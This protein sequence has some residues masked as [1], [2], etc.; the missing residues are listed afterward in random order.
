MVIA[1]AQR[2]VLLAASRNS[3]LREVVE[4]APVTRELV[5]R[6]VAGTG[7]DH[8]LEVATDLRGQGLLVTLDRLG[9]DVTDAA[10]AAA[11]R[12]AYVGLLGRLS[13]LG[14]TEGGAVETSS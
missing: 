13:A 2:T 4:R 5:R 10:D 7:D 6:F 9:E 1:E 11:T 8:A 14:L 12:D 3:R